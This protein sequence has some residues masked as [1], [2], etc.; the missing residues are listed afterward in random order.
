MKVR[1]A[2]IWGAV[3]ALGIGLC[4][5]AE[6][7]YL[8][9]FGGE[10]SEGAEILGFV[11]SFPL[12][13]L[14]EICLDREQFASQWTLFLAVATVANSALLGAIVGLATAFLWQFGRRRM[15]QGESSNAGAPRR[16]H[17]GEP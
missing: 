16:G 9:G 5:S 3:V 4:L 17:A 15:K 1:S 14:L 6:I 13:C 10:S 2:T 12:G 8:D 11:G 7:L